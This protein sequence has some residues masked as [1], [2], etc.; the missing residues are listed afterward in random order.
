MNC[1]KCGQ[2]SGSIT[3]RKCEREEEL[4]EMQHPPRKDCQ[5]E[6]WH[7]CTPMN[8]KKEKGFWLA[9][10]IGDFIG[11]GRCSNCGRTFWHNRY[12][13][14]LGFEGCDKCYSN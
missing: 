2:V 5:A 6:G 12:R 8:E 14:A 10:L 13:E 4:R 9:N 1:H 7:P 11:F 3:C